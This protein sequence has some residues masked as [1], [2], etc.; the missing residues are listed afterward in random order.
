MP[1][2]EPLGVLLAMPGSRAGQALRWGLRGLHAS[3]QAALQ[4]TDGD[5]GSV[6]LRQ[7]VDDLG[8]LLEGPGNV[9]PLPAEESPSLGLTSG[10]PT[11][12]SRFA[13]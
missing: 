9:L 4:E 10:A 7:L 13:S 1:W 2:P 6:A 12:G 8:P 3:L 5:P 11:S